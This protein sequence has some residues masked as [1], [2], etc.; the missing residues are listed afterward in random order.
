MLLAPEST[1]NEND[2]VFRFLAD[3]LPHKALRQKWA[4]FQQALQELDCFRLVEITEAHNVTALFHQRLS[5][6][7]L[8]H[9]LGSEARERLESKRR[10]SLA[11]AITRRKKTAALL[12]RLQAEGVETILLKGAAL[13]GWLF[14]EAGERQMRDIDLL[15]RKR[16]RE[17]IPLLMEDWGYR[18]KTQKRASVFFK[19]L[20]QH[21]FTDNEKDP[22][23]LVVEFHEYFGK[24][25]QFPIDY[26]ALFSQTM[27]HP[28][29]KTATILSPEE[30]AA[31]LSIHL[32]KH[33]KEEFLL[34]WLLDIHELACRF[35]LDW[36][37]LA[38]LAENWQCKKAVSIAFGL[39]KALF[40]A[41]VPETIVPKE[42]EQKAKKRLEALFVNQPPSHH[43]QF[44]NDIHEALSTSDSFRQLFRLGAYRTIRAL[45]VRL[46]KRKG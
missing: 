24:F 29:Y 45:D 20:N 35:G 10:L 30:C 22:F 44:F 9:E 26:D 1:T 41:S 31:Y 18:V 42:M 43:R 4:N 15:I 6:F 16:D 46:A 38:A 8:L 2:R 33:L 5:T 32:M 39:M 37:R 40:K 3:I 28:L 25:G 14:E 34:F 11:A 23:R 19:E 27:P 7:V 13:D 12:A 17:R 21:T 36:R